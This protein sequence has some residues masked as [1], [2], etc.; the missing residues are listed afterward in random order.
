[1]RLNLWFST[2]AAGLAASAAI[3]QPKKDDQAL[4]LNPE[5]TREGEGAKRTELTKMELKDFPAD[6]WGKLS[7]WQNGSASSFKGKAV[8][9]LTCSS[10]YRPSM[11]QF[12]AAKELAEKYAKQGLVVVAA[13]DKDGW[14]DADKAK[15]ADGATLIFAK[16]AKNEFRSTLRSDQDPDFYVID[17]A[18]HMRFADITN[19]SVEVAVKIV[20]GE[21]E[22]DAG[23][24]NDKIAAEKKR[25]EDELKKATQADSRVDLTKIPELPFTT[26]SDEDYAKAHWP[27]PYM[28]DQ[29]WEEYKKSGK[30]PE[31]KSFSMPTDGWIP[32]TPLFPGRVTIVFF[33]HPDWGDPSRLTAGFD[34]LSSMQTKYGRD[35]AVVLSVSNIF[36]EK[37]FLKVADTDPEK[38]IPRLKEFCKLRKIDFS[39]LMDLD[40]TLYNEAKPDGVT[41]YKGV[42]I[43]ILSSD[44]KVRYVVPRATNAML[45]NAV[46]KLI[47]IDPGVKARREVER[48]WIEAKG[49]STPK[50]EE[51]PA[52]KPPEKPAEKADEKK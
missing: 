35:L 21:S 45:D 49:K 51:K 18:G 33:F 40:N 17:K 8:L 37:D 44:S 13:F 30:L 24:L 16:D 15:P 11:K 48:K 22:A 14:G 50:T 19:E 28:T 26:P 32:K 42:I 27:L 9:V 6:A 52:E 46:S 10:W 29:Q 47:Q 25:L 1:M 3:A 38:M 43:A 2:I 39:F 12:D 4:L 7:D 20:T 36:E 23:K 41:D 34:W 5:V 31:P